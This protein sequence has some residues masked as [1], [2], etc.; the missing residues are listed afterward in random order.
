M[1]SYKSPFYGWLRATVGAL[2]SRAVENGET[3][4]DLDVDCI[5]DFLLAAPNVDLHLLP[6]SRA[7]DGPRAFSTSVASLSRWASC[8]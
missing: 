5:T 3:R 8:G 7:W 1:E 2:L 6:A 4:P